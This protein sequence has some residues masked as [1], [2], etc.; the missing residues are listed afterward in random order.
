MLSL[1]NPKMLMTKWVSSASKVPLTCWSTPEQTNVRFCELMLTRF[2]ALLSSTYSVH[3]Q[4]EVLSSLFLILPVTRA[5]ELFFFLTRECKNKAAIFNISYAHST[6]QRKEFS[7]R[8]VIFFSVLHWRDAVVLLTASSVCFML[9]T[10]SE[11]L[12]SSLVTLIKGFV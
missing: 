2:D 9:C 6:W 3:T 10:M 12:E 4:D 1:Q 7:F 8:F 5:L 11:S